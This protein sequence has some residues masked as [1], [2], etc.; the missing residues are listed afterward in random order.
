MTGAPVSVG[1][2]EQTRACYPDQDGYIESEGVRVFY[3]VYGEGEP[4]VLLLPTWGVVHSRAWKCQVPYL[5][6]HGRVVTFDRRGNGRSGRP[7]EV[8]E[9]DRSR[10]V[11]DA[12]AVLDTAGIERAVVLSW[13]C[14]G[15]DLMLAIDHPERV[16]GLIFVA[17]RSAAYRRSR[18]GGRPL[19]VRRRAA[20]V[21]GLGEVESPLLAS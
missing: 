5:A 8:P 10:A 18:R 14:A 11:D 4:S 16:A 1:V 13:C 20:N 15:D 2:R 21:G 12:L 9:Y 3:E 6:R 7:R 19:P 17:A